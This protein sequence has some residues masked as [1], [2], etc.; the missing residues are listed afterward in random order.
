VSLDSLNTVQ[1]AA[2]ARASAL[3]AK[4]QDPRWRQGTLSLR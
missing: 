2:S 1:Q 3:F 4:W